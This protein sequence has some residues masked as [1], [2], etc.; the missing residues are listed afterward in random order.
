ME[1]VLQASAAA[2]DAAA[3]AA[4]TSL[5]LNTSTVAAAPVSAELTE[6][7]KARV[8]D[9]LRAARDECREQEE[10]FARCRGKFARLGAAYQVKPR[11]ADAELTPEYFFS[12]WVTF[13]LHFKDAW[14]R[15]TQK[16]NKQRYRR[17]FA[18]HGSLPNLPFK[19][20]VL[21]P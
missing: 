1:R 17:H 5:N 9:F 8:A 13:C 3:A 16:L 12:L 10:N 20:I 21:S 14:K 7:F 18:F 4:N 2:A 11:A 15:E 6:L 19:H